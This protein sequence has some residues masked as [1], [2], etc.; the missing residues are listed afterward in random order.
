MVEKFGTGCKSIVPLSSCRDWSPRKNIKKKK[1]LK[2]ETQT[3]RNGTT[4]STMPKVDPPVM[5]DNDWDG[6]ETGGECVG[7]APK[8][9]AVH[10]HPPP[11]PPRCFS[12][13]R[14]RGFLFVILCVWMCVKSVWKCKCVCGRIGD[15]GVES[16]AGNSHTPKWVCRTTYYSEYILYRHHLTSRFIFCRSLSRVFALK[17]RSSFEE[18]EVPDL[19]KTFA[20]RFGR[21]LPV[22]DYF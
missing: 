22:W 10:A 11:P 13:E 4:T 14:K 21:C 18:H 9:L 16:P 3:R 6:S 1:Y 7:R 12:I 19:G 8:K 15:H 2:N 17:L 20:L 5:Q